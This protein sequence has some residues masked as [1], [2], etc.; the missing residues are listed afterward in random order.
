MWAFVMKLSVATVVGSTSIRSQTEPQIV[1]IRIY[2]YPQTCSLQIER[3]NTRKVCQHCLATLGRC[4]YN[5]VE[6]L[7]QRGLKRMNTQPQHPSHQE[8]ITCKLF[9]VPR[10]L[11]REESTST[12][13][14]FS[15]L[16]K[17]IFVMYGWRMDS[18]LYLSLLKS[19][20]HPLPGENVQP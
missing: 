14:R 18:A 12:A 10:R 19:S 5:R 13:G 20:T 11:L 7:K 17:Y 1:H 9:N 6:D 15:M 4:S 8:H 16:V 2:P 3:N